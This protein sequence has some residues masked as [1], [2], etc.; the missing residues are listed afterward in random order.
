MTGIVFTGLILFFALVRLMISFINWLSR[1]YIPDK[2][3][4]G[5]PLISVLIPARNEEKTL[6]VLLE[7][8]LMQD[9]GNM[10]IL[11]YNDHSEDQTGRIVDSFKRKDNRIRAIDPVDL[12][13]G[14]LGKNFACHNLARH[15]K[16]DYL[17]FLDADVMIAPWL[18]RS[19][20]AYTQLHNLGLL[21]V[22]PQQ[23]MKS[24]GEKLTVPLMNWILLTL[25]PM[26]L[27]RK[28]SRPS[29]AAA[30]GQFMLF[31]KGAYTPFQW[32]EQ[33]KDNLVEDI[34]IIRK[35]KQKGERTATLLGNKDVMCRMYGNYKEAINGFA[36]N[37]IE[38][39]GGKVITALLFVIIVLGGI[40]IPFLTNM[41]LFFVYL[42][43]VIL[44]RIFVSLSSR[45]PVVCNLF[46]HVFQM[47]T[48]VLVFVKGTYVKITGK[49]NWKGR[50]I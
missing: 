23:I 1:L 50:S 17:L 25:L 12:P 5:N 24:M 43:L 18:I 31:R 8:L 3:P 33:V 46:L 14:W 47:I 22:F 6:P 4:E 36:K 37:V 42:I 30:N 21:S 41:T 48:F 9:Y 28:S 20:L 32:H 34:V 27:V 15:A 45:Q 29:L 35:M 16:G 40:A 2:K 38:F 39:F 10:E 13:E 44:I 19:A 26:I 7:G 11:I 49:Y